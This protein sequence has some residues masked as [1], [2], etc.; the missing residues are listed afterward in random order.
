V[1]KYVI[2]PYIGVDS[3]KFWMKPKEVETI[4]GQPDSVS[5][6][7]LKQR[8]EFRSF[9]NIAYSPDEHEN[10]VHFGFGRQ[11]VDLNYKNIFLFTEE[12]KIALQKLIDEDHQPFL[13]L[14]FVVF[15][16]LG[17]TLTGFHDEDISQKAVTLFPHGAWD[18]RIPK[19]K[20]FKF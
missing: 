6:N 4:I 1:Q 7:H 3:L 13:Y 11:M 20:P 9:M 15:L 8:V 17:M 5:I 16:N 18:K 19:L 2:T 10:L 14:G 12:A